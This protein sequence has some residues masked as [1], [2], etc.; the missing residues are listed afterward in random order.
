MSATATEQPAAE[1]TK[2]KR[3]HHRPGIGC[4]GRNSG[5]K[6]DLNVMDIARASEA[7]SAKMLAKARWGSAELMPCPHC[8]TIDTH[9]WRTYDLRWKC[10]GCGKTFSVTSNT[11]FA[12]H[13]KSLS[14]I[15][16]RAFLWMNHA[17]GTPALTAAKNFGEHYSV[18][19][20]VRQ[21]LREGLLRGHNVG[22]TCGVVEADGMDINGRRAL[23]KRGKPQVSPPKKAEIPKHLVADT[24]EKPPKEEK[25]AKQPAARRILLSM[26][27]RG[28]SAGSG[29]T[30]TRVGISVVEDSQSVEALARRFVSAESRFETDEDH[31]YAKFSKLFAGH[32]SVAHSQTFSENGVNNN[33]AESFNARARRAAEGIYLNISNKYLLE[34]AGEAAFRED[35]RD[36]SVRARFMHMFHTVFSVGKS[37]WFRNY[38]KPR[39]R[40]RDFEPLVTGQLKTHARGPTPGRNPYASA[41]GFPPR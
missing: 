16:T 21:K 19:Y 33:Q 9:Y 28:I 25:K 24:P 4:R 32:A 34:Y 13:K 40:K 39:T 35:C 1:P 12:D 30:A 26:R 36:L 22:M 23:E 8:G 6:H 14:D 29:A 5:K 11:V 18:T 17:S 10:K 27:Q 37:M 7:E 41:S 20:P 2:P 38:T 31:A 3:K 15:A